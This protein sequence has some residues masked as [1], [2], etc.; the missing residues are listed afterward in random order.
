[1]AKENISFMDARRLADKERS[2][3]VPPLSSST[4]QGPSAGRIIPG[5]FY[6]T[7]VRSPDPISKIL[8]TS[9]NKG[10]ATRLAKRAEVH[11]EIND[12]IKL[13]EILLTY[14]DKGINKNKL[15]DLFS[16]LNSKSQN[17]ES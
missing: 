8:L 1:M 6:S 5:P 9:N 17:G 16:N 11:K 4:E 15:F 3:I 12:L 2:H 13:G 14:Y 10:F 7:M